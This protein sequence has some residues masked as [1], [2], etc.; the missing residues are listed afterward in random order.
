MLNDAGRLIGDFTLCRVSADRFFVV[1]T[2][3]AEV[4]YLRWFEQ[5]LPPTGVTVRPCAMEYLGLSVAGPQSR[6]LLQTLVDHDLSTAAF[7][8]MSFAQMDVGMVP[9]LVGRVSFTGEMGYEIVGDVRVPAHAVRP[10]A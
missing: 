4:F 10:A 6:A 3:A 2:Y 8:F 7:P 5:H 1:G 9:A